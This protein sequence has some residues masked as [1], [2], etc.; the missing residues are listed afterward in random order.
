[1][2]K[3]KCPFCNYEYVPSELYLPNDF[4][5][6][7]SFVARDDSGKITHHV[8]GDM[9]LKETY[10]CDSCNNEFEVEA[11]VEFKTVKLSQ[12]LPKVFRVSI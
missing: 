9:N 11:T 1:M 6:K 5:G 3:I 10:V 12:E 7:A 4:L 8:D 2:H